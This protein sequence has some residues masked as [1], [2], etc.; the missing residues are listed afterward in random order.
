MTYVYNKSGQNLFFV[1]EESEYGHPYDPEDELTKFTILAAN[2]PHWRKFDLIPDA[3]DIVLPIIE[4]IK[5]FDTSDSKHASAILSGNIEPVEFTIDMDAQGL[6]FLPTS[7]GPPAFSSHGQAMVQTITC[8]AESGNITQGDYFLIDAITSN[9]VEHFAVWFGTS[10]ETGKP[11]ITGINATNVLN[12]QLS[13]TTPTSTA[14]Q[15]ATAVKTILDLDATFGAASTGAVVTVTH[16]ASGAVQPAHDS[17]VAPSVCTFA[18]TTWGSTTYT[19]TEALDTNLPSFTI[20]AEQKNTTTDEDIVWDIFGCVVESVEVSVN[21]GDKIVKCSVTFKTPYA[22]ENSNGR[23]T[24][25]PPR[26]M[27]DAFPTMLA[28]KESAAA[29]LLM[30]GTTDRTPQTVDSVVLNIS[31]NVSFK[32]DISA[33]YAILAVAAK[34]DITLR[35]VG[36]TQ[37]KELFTYYQGAYKA[38][39]TDWVPTGGIGGKLNSKFKLQ[40]D[41]TYDYINISFYSWLLKEHNFTFV[42]VDEAVKSVDMTLEDGNS[43]TNGRVIDSATF[44]SYIDRTIMIEKDTV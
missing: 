28:L 24:N 22:L 18:V 11:T 1:R 21:F 31:N 36:A 39:G 8:P 10:G 44:V 20:H 7:F 27:I 6:E 19:I 35:I 30:E 29:Y 4:K 13:A 17:G 5:K 33:R 26:K 34:R 32:S 14:T 42:S 2:Y 40:R 25:P 3:Q 16:A 23:N 37:E 41:A 12:A 43:D 15:V 38:E 9:T